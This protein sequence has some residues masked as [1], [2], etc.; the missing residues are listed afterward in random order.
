MKVQLLITFDVFRKKTSSVHSTLLFVSYL[1]HTF[2][3][4]C[5]SNCRLLSNNKKEFFDKVT[6]TTPPFTTFHQPRKVSEVASLISETVIISVLDSSIKNPL[7]PSLPLFRNTTIPNSHPDCTYRK[8]SGIFS[9]HYLH[10]M[11]QSP[12][13]HDLHDSKQTNA[14]RF[15]Q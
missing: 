1:Q 3:T 5:L 13:L 10:C 2:Q 6:R 7:P 4:T 14:H 8:R 11:H 12:F 9:L 15:V